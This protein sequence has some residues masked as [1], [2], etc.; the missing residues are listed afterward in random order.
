MVVDA[1]PTDAGVLGFSNPWCPHVLAAAWPLS[2][3]EGPTVQIASAPTF[4]ATKWAAFQGR[5][6][7]ADVHG[8]HDLEDIL[9][10]LD[11]RAETL[12]EVNAAAPEVRQALASAFESLCENARFLDALPGLVE[13][14]REEIVLNR[15]REIAGL[16]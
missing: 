5:D 6:G 14:G 15:L 4:L 13:R 9:T 8:S 11:A 1:M 12:A 2:F 3:D 16:A 10:V 7:G